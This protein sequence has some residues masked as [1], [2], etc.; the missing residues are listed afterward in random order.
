MRMWGGVRTKAWRSFAGVSPVRAAGVVAG[1]EGGGRLAGAGG[2]GDEDVAAGADEGPAGGLGVRGGLEAA[3][4][5]GLDDGV[6]G[7][8]GVIVRGNTPRAPRQGLRPCTPL[9][10]SYHLRRAYPHLV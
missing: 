4:E 3:P 8:E 10:L 6:E 7:R 2:R 1:G 9:S 5:P